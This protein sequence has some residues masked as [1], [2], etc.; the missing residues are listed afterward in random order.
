MFS[1]NIEAGPE[2]LA[3]AAVDSGAF[4][5]CTVEK[6]WG[7]LYNRAPTPDE[8]DTVTALADDFAADGYQ[9]KNLIQTLVMRPEYVQGGRFEKER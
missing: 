1:P 7:P 8:T 4:A 3:R 9:L 6:M 5:R 2:A